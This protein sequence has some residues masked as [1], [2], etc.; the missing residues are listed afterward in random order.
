MSKLWDLWDH[1]G[2][3]AWDDKM[4]AQVTSSRPCPDR[5]Q[6]HKLNDV[7]LFPSDL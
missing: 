1:G 7:F 2:A 5:H 4:E 6:L 3:R